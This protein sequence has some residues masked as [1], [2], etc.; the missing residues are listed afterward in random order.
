MI[1][2]VLQGSDLLE[3][4]ENLLSCSSVFLKL[5]ASEKFG[6]GGRKCLLKFRF[7]GLAPT[8]SHLQNLRIK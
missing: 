2:M 5:V 6:G 8:S 7:Q 4:E 1:E 3:I